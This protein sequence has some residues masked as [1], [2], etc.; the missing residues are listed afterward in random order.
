MDTGA[1]MGNLATEYEQ[2]T[3]E[4]QQGALFQPATIK[5]FAFGV[6]WE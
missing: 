2:A 4:G 3:K 6:T 5:P 1:D